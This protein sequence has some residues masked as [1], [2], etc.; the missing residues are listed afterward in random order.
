MFLSVQCRFKW[1]LA[2]LS[3]TRVDSMATDGQNT[4]NGVNEVD[5]KLKPPVE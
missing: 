3:A 5:G 2:E 4:T 1:R